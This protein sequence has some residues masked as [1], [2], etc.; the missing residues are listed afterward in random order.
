MVGS[1]DLLVTPVCRRCRIAESRTL[2]LDVV[3]DGSASKGN[4][5]GVSN[6][7]R[8]TPLS[9]WPIGLAARNNVE[10]D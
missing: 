9:D 6:V 4:W 8:V 7:P 1:V 2:L 10:R 3:R 5:H